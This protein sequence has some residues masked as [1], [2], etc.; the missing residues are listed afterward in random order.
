MVSLLRRTNVMITLCTYLKSR[1]CICALR[2]RYYNLN[3]KR[4]LK[5]F[6]VMLFR[7]YV[8]SM[9]GIKRYI[10]AD[11]S[12]SVLAKKKEDHPSLA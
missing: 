2:Y 9:N 7:H 8:L 12:R 1:L 4:S 3:S 11:L 10:F 6:L 5:L